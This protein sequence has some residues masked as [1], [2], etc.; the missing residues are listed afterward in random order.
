MRRALLIFVKHPEPGRVKTRLAATVGA[1]RAAEIYRQLAAEIFARLPDDA[2]AIACFDPPERREEIERWLNGIAHG[3]PLR[4]LPQSAGDLGARLT[5]AFAE[6]FALGFQQVAA[7]GTDC[8]EIDAAIFT[9]AWTALDT[10]DLAIGQ[11]EDGGYYLIALAA[12]HPALFERIPWSTGSVFTETLVRAA[13]ENLRIHRLPM[14]CD[15]DTEEDWRSAEPR[16]SSRL[17]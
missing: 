9:E 6:T 3:K 14:R 16:L 11:S 13:S 4:F 5:Q 2:E 17:I 1:Q 12:P 10:H 7:I 8:I 15:V